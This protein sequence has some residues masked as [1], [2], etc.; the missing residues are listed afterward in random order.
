MIRA[1]YLIGADDYYSI[2][3]IFDLRGRSYADVM[4]YGSKHAPASHSFSSADP[5]ELLS[6][7]LL[8]MDM[9]HVKYAN[10]LQFKAEY[11]K[12]VVDL[13]RAENRTRTSRKVQS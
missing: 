2:D 6:M 3:V 11:K 4:T 13:E 7:I 12:Q 9:Y 10:I 1:A 8:D 5:H